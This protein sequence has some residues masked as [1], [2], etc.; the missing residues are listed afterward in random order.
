MRKWWHWLVFIFALIAVLSLVVIFTFD[1]SENE[2][3]FFERLDIIIL[4]VFALDL[5]NEFKNF[6]GSKKSFPREHWLDIVAV[7]PLFR[8]LRISR[9]ARIEELVKIERIIDLEK[10]AQTEE[11]ISKTIHGSHVKTKEKEFED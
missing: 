10:G 9:I 8:F 6:K 7:I 5:F 11:V 4:F 3:V 1:L 2:K